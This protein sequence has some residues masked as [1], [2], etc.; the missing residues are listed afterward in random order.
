[1][2]MRGSVDVLLV[3]LYSPPPLLFMRQIWHIEEKRGKNCESVFFSCAANSVTCLMSC[4]AAERQKSKNTPFL[5]RLTFSP[6]EKK[7]KHI[8]KRL[9]FLY[10]EALA[11]LILFFVFKQN[12][13]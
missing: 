2:L 6:V 4:L 13:P 7:T 12:K 5:K 10:K 11:F 1:M 8:L 9:P 3:R